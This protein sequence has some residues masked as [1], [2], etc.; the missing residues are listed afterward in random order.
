MKTD[1][2]D[3]VIWFTVAAMAVR[4]VGI[5]MGWWSAGGVL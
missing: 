1:A 3:L 2:L 5:G 4:L